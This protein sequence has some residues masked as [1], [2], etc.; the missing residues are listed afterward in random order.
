M[1]TGDA[2]RYTEGFE[3]TQSA[4]HDLE[5]AWMLFERVVRSTAHS[6]GNAINVVSGRLSLLELD[7]GLSASGRESLG[8]IRERLRKTHSELK[9]AVAF[10][11]GERPAPSAH[12]VSA[13]LG[14]LAQEYGLEVTEVQTGEQQQLPRGHSRVRLDVPLRSLCEACRELGNEPARRVRWFLSAE[15][16]DSLVLTLRFDQEQLPADRRLVLEPW[17]EPAAAGLPDSQRY[18]RLLLATSLGRL[19]EGGANVSVSQEDGRERSG[20]GANDATQAPAG[21]TIG[22]VPLA[23]AVRVV[24][25]E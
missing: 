22:S 14:A 7:D 2:D 19:E 21:G 16:T 17:F 10:A 1:D 8:L 4:S 5:K 12:E 20:Q 15:G 18:A 13:Q 3:G 11:Y 6:V 24:W 25:P 23:T 9:G